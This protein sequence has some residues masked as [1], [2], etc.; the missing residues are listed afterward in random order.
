MSN[1][2]LIDLYVT[3][4]NEGVNSPEVKGS[5]LKSGKD[6]YGDVKK[7]KNDG[8]D[9][10]VK[11]D[12]PDAPKHLSAEDGNEKT[13]KPT[14]AK[15]VNASANPFDAL[16]QQFISEDFGDEHGVP[17]AGGM[18]PGVTP[19]GGMESGMDDELPIT[20]ENI[21]EDEEEGAEGG[22]SGVISALEKALE[23]L[24]G[25]APGGSEEEEGSEGLDSD[26]DFEDLGVDDE[27][28]D[29]EFGGDLSKESV[30]ISKA[31]DKKEAFQGANKS[32]QV[33][34]G[35]PA[36]KGKATTPSTG[37]GNDGKLEKMA[38]KKDTFQGA[39]KSNDTKL[40]KTGKSLF[41]Q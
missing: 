7:G 30:E 5:T 35:V 27:T 26:E 3:T 23:A 1:N 20:D 25:L 34:G 10:N 12:K 13:G 28:S 32:N 22:I 39:T 24:R 2:P 15:L 11:L 6:V 33:K 17:S 8:P 29:L 37:K 9:A 38:D 18:N 19:D 40:V 16:Y 14:K 31:P 4:L 41:E 36:K 21:D